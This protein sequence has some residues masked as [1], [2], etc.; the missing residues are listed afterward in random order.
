MR[1]RIHRVGRDVLAVLAIVALS[2]IA[3]QPLAGQGR[4]TPLQGLSGGQL[5]TA[6]LE[7][8]NWIVV[9]W[10]SWSPK[11]RDIAAR[12]NAIESAWSRKARVVTVNFQEKRP[13]IEKFLSGQAMK[14][15]VYLDSSGAFSKKNAVTTLPGVLIYKDGKL[16][17]R[18]RLPDDADA[19]IG[20]FLG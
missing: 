8:G 1:D 19:L 2:A 4:E 3:A 10:A 16:A 13:D 18:G 6:D 15:P 14:P 12:V 20:R 17:H 9:V 5:D 7:S 11:G